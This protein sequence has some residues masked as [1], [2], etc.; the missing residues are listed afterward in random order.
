[1]R[2]IRIAYAPI[3][4]GSSARKRLPSGC[5]MRR[6]IWNPGSTSSAG[7]RSAGPCVREGCMAGHKTTEEQA[8]VMMRLAS[9]IRML[10]EK[11]NMSIRDFAEKLNIGHSDLFR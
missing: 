9:T 3:A 10:R 11:E 6:E 8:T 5:G 4:I 7:M 1:M 2:G